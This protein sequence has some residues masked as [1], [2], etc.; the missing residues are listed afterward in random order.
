MEV[1]PEFWQSPEAVNDVLH[2]SH[3]RRRSPTERRGPLY[4]HNS[5]SRCESPRT[6]P[7]RYC[8]IQLDAGWLSDASREIDQLEQS[9]GMPG[10]IHGMYSGTLQAFRDSLSTEPMLIVTALTV[11]YIVLGILYESYIHPITIFRRS[12]R[13]GGR[14]PCVLLFHIDM[15]S[16]QSLA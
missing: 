5:A 8:L 14:S 10:S 7:I 13:R 15:T 12:L 11:V 6:I 4:A 1:A 2:P 9:M 16:L 3:K